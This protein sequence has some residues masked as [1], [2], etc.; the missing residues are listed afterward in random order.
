MVLVR[1]VKTVPIKIQTATAFRFS[2]TY[3]NGRLSF[4]LLPALQSSPLF[5]LSFFLSSRRLGFT[6]TFSKRAC[7]FLFITTILHTSYSLLITMLSHHTLLYLVA[8]AASSHMVAGAPT[9][10]YG[11]G[12][13]GGGGGGS[14]VD[15]AADLSWGI[16]VLGKYL[17]S[18][19]RVSFFSHQTSEWY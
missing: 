12:G 14:S 5:F 18:Y 6:S 3:K 13:G 17:T 19:H 7:S 16:K 1:S 10:G 9:Y 2:L 15:G 11:G 4:L 8:L